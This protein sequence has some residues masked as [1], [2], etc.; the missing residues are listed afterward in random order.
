MFYVGLKERVEIVIEM[1]VFLITTANTLLKIEGF[2][3]IE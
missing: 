1:Y 2:W 3:M